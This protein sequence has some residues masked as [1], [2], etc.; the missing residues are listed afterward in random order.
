MMV[1]MTQPKRETGESERAD[2]LQT[3]VQGTSSYESTVH[4]D[5]ESARYMDD[6]VSL[7]LTA[8]F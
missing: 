8:W 2:F 5:T 7:L 3:V 4:L 6:P 1:M